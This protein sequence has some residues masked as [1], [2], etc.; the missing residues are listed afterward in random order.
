MIWNYYYS[1]IVIN[2][3]F[4]KSVKPFAKQN[5]CSN[6]YMII[7]ESKVIINGQ[8][9][10]DTIYIS[11]QVILGIKVVKFPREWVRFRIEFIRLMRKVVAVYHQSVS[12][13]IKNGIVVEIFQSH[14]GGGKIFIIV[15]GTSFEREIPWM[16]INIVL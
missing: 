10:I 11:V 1:G 12:G 3:F 5:I 6:I 16:I 2:T 14:I 15:S 13:L 9:H 7:C 4:A 8:I